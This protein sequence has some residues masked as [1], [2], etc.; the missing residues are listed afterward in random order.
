[1]CVH[2][3]DALGA[4]NRRAE[5]LDRLREAVQL[6]PDYWEAR[7][8]MG[9]E[10]ALQ[11]RIAEARE[12]FA[13]VVRLQPN[14]ALGHLNL[15]VALAKQGRLDDALVQFRETLR[16]DPR[17]KLAQQHRETIESLKSRGP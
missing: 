2:T 5:A 17:N 13:E 6:R 4:L 1:M 16:L 14:Y 9:V 7:Y 12:Q 8:F 15:G 3:A 11:D 10:L